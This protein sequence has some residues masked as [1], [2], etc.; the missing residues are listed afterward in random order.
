MMLT[1]SE[2]LLG[3]LYKIE[4]VNVSRFAQCTAYNKFIT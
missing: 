2:N 1:L 3:L 4:K